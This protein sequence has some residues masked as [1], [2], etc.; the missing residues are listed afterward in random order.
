VERFG[1]I[2]TYD[3]S[4]GMYDHVAPQPEPSPDGIPPIDLPPDSVCYSVT[5]PTCNFTWTGYRIPLIVVSPFAKKNYVSHTVADSTAIL[6]F[7]EDAVQS[8]RPQ[9]AGCGSAD[10]SEFFDFNNPPW[11]TPPTPPS[12]NPATRVT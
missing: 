8:T 7:V 3:E 4:G 6:K 12:Q 2:F 5:G 9:Q 10:L 1:V 11:M